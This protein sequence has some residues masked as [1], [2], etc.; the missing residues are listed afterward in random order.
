MQ[1]RRGWTGEEKTTTSSVRDCSWIPVDFENARQGNFDCKSDRTPQ[2]AS[3]EVGFE[4]VAIYADD[5]DVPT[6]AARSLPHGVWSS[7][8]GDGEDIE[9]TTLSVVEG[10]NYGKA[11]RFLKRSR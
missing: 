9:H 1:E 5:N 4:K 11:K 7:K 10:R 8:M 6:H 3:I 2:Y